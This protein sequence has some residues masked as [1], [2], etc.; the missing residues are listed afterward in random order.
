MIGGAA[1]AGFRPSP[2]AELIARIHELPSRGKPKNEGPPNDD[3]GLEELLV[4]EQ[5]RSTSRTHPERA[6]VLGHVQAELSEASRL[7][8]ASTARNERAAS[9]LRALLLENT[10][11]HTVDD[12]WEL[13]G[14]IKRLNL[15]LGQCDRTYVQGLLEHENVY[16]HDPTH[17]HT[18]DEHYPEAELSELLSAYRCSRVTRSQRE[19]AL[20]RLNFL[21]LKR[22]EAGRDRRA[23]AALKD[24]YLRHLALVLLPF[25]LGLWAIAC[26][27]STETQS[28]W[29][30]FATAACA[31]A[32]G[33]TLSGVL[34]LRDQLVKLDELRAF[35]PAM[36]VQPLV[37]ASAG[38]LAF[39]V[40]ASNAVSIG[41]LDAKAW[42]SPG[43]LGFLA[44]F[45]EP[46]FLG[47]VDRVAG[48]PEAGAQGGATAL[49]GAGTTASS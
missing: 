8:A 27:S 39:L 18:W 34:R 13:F 33:S 36:L 28:V 20:D 35:K 11:I 2:L 38:A 41:S 6:K 5:W 9:E 14:R 17:W 10:R 15:R 1:D 22:A 26:V 30:S 37:G 21:Y 24:L 3:A 25:L 7:L 23:K 47:L 44:G 19:R 40:L 43:L 48:L 4:R 46:F 12:G 16:V 45:S 31:G 29:R 42:S 32:L 49:A